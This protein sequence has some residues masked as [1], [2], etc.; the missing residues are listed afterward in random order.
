MPDGWKCTIQVYL[1]VSCQPLFDG[2]RKAIRVSEPREARSVANTSAH[3]RA[4][5]VM[6]QWEWHRHDSH[7]PERG[8]VFPRAGSAAAHDPAG[9][10]HSKRRRLRQP[11]RT[12][13]GQRFHLNALP[14]DER[15]ARDVG[16]LAADNQ[17]VL[18]DSA[19]D[20]LIGRVI[21][22]MNVRETGSRGPS[23]RVIMPTVCASRDNH[24]P[25]DNPAGRV[26]AVSL[27]VGLAVPRQSRKGGHIP[28][29]RRRTGSAY[30]MH[31]SCEG[32]VVVD[33]FGARVPQAVTV[34]A[35]RDECSTYRRQVAPF[36]VQF[37]KS[38][39]IAPVLLMSFAVNHTTGELPTVIPINPRSSI[40]ELGVHRK[41]R[42]APGPTRG[43][44]PR[45][46]WRR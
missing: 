28:L 23:E 45:P 2:C 18:V 32:P 38:P 5:G 9:V 16:V 39:T 6:C 24:K 7:L 31:L 26:D 8:M 42:L 27:V 12:D 33:R 46:A 34:G 3:A 4:S 11:R 1:E 14:V 10:I 30:A 19:R 17:A 36:A 20:A 22:R 40:P 44:C 35:E 41:P 37:S 29:I 13:V 15:A 21:R 43:C 25:S